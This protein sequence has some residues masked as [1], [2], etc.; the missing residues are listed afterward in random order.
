MENGRAKSEEDHRRIYHGLV[1]RCIDGASHPKQNG[2][3]ESQ[4]ERPEREVH[5][6]L[7]P[8]R[9]ILLAACSNIPV[10]GRLVEDTDK[11]RF[12]GQL[13]RLAR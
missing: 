13:R 4:A 6:D 5:L 11:R 7:F 8:I 2:L 10:S 3:S 1:I 9:V 12:D